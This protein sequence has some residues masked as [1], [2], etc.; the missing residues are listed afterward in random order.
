MGPLKI[1][2]H[3][4]ETWGYF[5][6]LLPKPLRLFLLCPSFRL[7]FPLLRS[8]RTFPGRCLLLFWSE[9]SSCQYSL[10]VRAMG[11]AVVTGWA[12]AELRTAGAVWWFM[13]TLAG[14]LGGTA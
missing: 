8:L 1:Y 7:L 6:M 11:L 13:G 9:L 2:A 3:N 4:I 12:G 14:L 10:E 5:L